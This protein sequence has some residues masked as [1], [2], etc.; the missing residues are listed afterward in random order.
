MQQGLAALQIE[1][2]GGLCVHG[3]QVVQAL[4]RFRFVVIDGTGVQRLAGE[5]PQRVRRQGLLCFPGVAAEKGR[6]HGIFLKIPR[7]RYVHGLRQ[8]LRCGH[9]AFLPPV[10]VGA[11]VVLQ[12]QPRRNIHIPHKVQLRQQ[13]VRRF[14]C[15]GGG[16]ALN[17]RDE[18]AL[19][20]DDGQV[21][22]AVIAGQIA[23]V[24]LLE[25]PGSIVQRPLV[26]R[27]LGGDSIAAADIHVRKRR[28]WRRFLFG[29]PFYRAQQQGT[30]QQHKGC[31]LH[32]VSHACIASS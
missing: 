19:V 2:V 22:M 15:R 4:L 28:R 32:G 25:L 23:V 24:E 10:G 17:G 14:L 1:V 6:V 12:R 16:I 5:I 21:N 8:R 18:A 27:R 26:I 11:V 3:G 9:K 7:Q 20:G 30:A 31:P 29:H 13:R